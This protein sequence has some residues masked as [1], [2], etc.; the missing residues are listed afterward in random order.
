MIAFEPWYL[1]R[2]VSV[3]GQ[4][5]FAITL[6]D[7]T[8]IESTSSA[9]SEKKPVDKIRKERRETYELSH[10]DSKYH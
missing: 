5:S 4:S 8:P 7:A 6:Y 9:H 2:T 3:S 10:R 1:N